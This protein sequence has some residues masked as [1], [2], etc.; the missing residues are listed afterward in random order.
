MKISRAEWLSFAETMW[1]QL[2]LF[3]I[4]DADPEEIQQLI[5]WAQGDFLDRVAAHW[6]LER[7]MPLWN[8]TRETDVELRIRI[9]WWSDLSKKREPK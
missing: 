6:G 4:A 7:Y 2:V 5:D 8:S 9:K 3:K 1:Y